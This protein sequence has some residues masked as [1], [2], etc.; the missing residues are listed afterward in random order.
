LAFALN[1]RI[2]AGGRSYWVGN[3]L[4]FSGLLRASRLREGA[5]S[6][7]LFVMRGGTFERVALD[8]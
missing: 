4:R 2:V 8:Q 7:E 1:G 6:V 5:N 3:A